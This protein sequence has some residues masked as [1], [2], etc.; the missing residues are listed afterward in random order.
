MLGQALLLQAGKKS[1]C[2]IYWCIK[3]ADSYGQLW[4]ENMGKMNGMELWIKV[5]LYCL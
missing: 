1:Q 2:I 4:K 5:F 3:C